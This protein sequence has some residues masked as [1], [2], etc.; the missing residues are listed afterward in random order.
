MSEA[1]PRALVLAER[2]HPQ[3][4]WY[5]F[6]SQSWCNEAAALLRQQHDAIVALRRELGW[7]CKAAESGRVGPDS[8]ALDRAR[9]TLTNTEGLSK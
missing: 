5:E 7:L 1:K 3:T 6:D 4:D 2:I 9:A 8:A